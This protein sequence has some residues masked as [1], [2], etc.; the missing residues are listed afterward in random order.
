MLAV[1]AGSE[2]VLLADIAG[3]TVRW[4]LVNRE[5]GKTGEKFSGCVRHW[6]GFHSGKG[7]SGRD[8]HGD[9]VF[10]QTSMVAVP[11]EIIL[12]GDDV[13]I[14]VDGNDGS[15]EYQVMFLSNQ[16]W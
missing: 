8:A 6:A 7:G 4:E 5:Y 1:V 15:N 11:V 12:D 2:V 13:E 9:G 14:G 16:C 3:L 10:L